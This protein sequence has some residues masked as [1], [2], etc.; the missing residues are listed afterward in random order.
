MIEKKFNTMLKTNLQVSILW[1]LMGAT[2]RHK[3]IDNKETLKNLNKIDVKNG[4]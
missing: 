2:I 4:D 1:M 3:Y